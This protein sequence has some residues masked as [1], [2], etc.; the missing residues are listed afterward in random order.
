MPPSLFNDTET[1]TYKIENLFEPIFLAFNGK[2]CNGVLQFVKDCLTILV[3]YVNLMK[4]FKYGF[5]AIQMALYNV[6]NT[7]C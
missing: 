1:H 2:E 6:L 4:I 7:E 5:T 3:T